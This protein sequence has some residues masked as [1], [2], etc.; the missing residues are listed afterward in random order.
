MTVV[1]LPYMKRRRFLL[2]DELDIITV[3]AF[4]IVGIIFLT[5]ILNYF[6]FHWF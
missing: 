6:Y 2:S 4:V 1:K 5:F 3:S